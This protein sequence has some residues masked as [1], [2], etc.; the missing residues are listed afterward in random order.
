M[1]QLALALV[2]VAT[3]A[4]HGALAQTTPDQAPPKVTPP[5]PRA[6]NPVPPPLPTP[7]AV[8]PTPFRPPGATRAPLNP[9]VRTQATPSLAQATNVPVVAPKD[10]PKI[11]FEKTVYDFGKV[12]QPEKVDGKFVFQ[13]VGA[14]VLKL[15]KPTTSCGCT[16][17]GV[18]PDTLQPGEKGEL[19]FTLTVPA[20]KVKLEKQIF[21]TCNDPLSPRVT[22]SVKAEHEPLYDYTP[23][24][25]N[26][27][28]RQGTTTNVPIMVKRTDGQKLN[29]TKIE[30]N[31]TN[32]LSAKVQPTEPPDDK[33]A[34]LIVT[35]KAE[36][37][38]RR[39]GD[40]VR[41]FTENSDKPAFQVWSNVRIIGDVVWTP[42]AVVWNINDPAQARLQKQDWMLTRRLSV[43]SGIAGQTLEVTN[44]TTDLKGVELQVV[45]TE[46]G[47]TY[48]I[49]A[50]L[51]EIPDQTTSGKLTFETN[52]GTQ[53]K[54][55]IPMIVSVVKR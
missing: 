53:K 7:P 4:W 22:L 26:L 46:K 41:V 15:E 14:G 50:K 1:K 49:V 13:N 42:D 39:A 12:T 11:H 17:A 33:A 52:F 51:S 38:P 6:V 25:I 32:W 30:N 23:S 48:A 44:P 8:R 36:G 31:A 40:W 55:E 20:S 34:R 43:T 19:A 2:I 35:M 9:L 28:L 27:T 29:I 37:G 45:P 5:A 54:V 16:I 10:A 18:K 47:K 3:V 21:V 24:M